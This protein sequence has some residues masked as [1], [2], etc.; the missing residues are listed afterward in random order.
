MASDQPQQLKMTWPMM[1]R[2]QISIDGR[3]VRLSYG[4]TAIVV[5][6]LLRRGRATPIDL[7]I[8]ILYP[9][10][11][12]EPEYAANLIRRHICELRRDA[13]LNIVTSYCHGYYLP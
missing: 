13:G 3:K 1:K 7:L 9:D 4:K 2:K 10:P 12:R 11:D 5:T 8:E 6:L